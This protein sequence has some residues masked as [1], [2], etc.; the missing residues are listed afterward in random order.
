M[1]E[2]SPQFIRAATLRL[3]PNDDVV[4][5]TREL[6]AGTAIAAE[7]VTTAERIPV[8]HKVA[9]RAV[10]QGQPVRRYNQ[11][12]GTAKVDIAMGQIVSV[13]PAYSY[14]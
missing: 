8:G 12:I 11:I 14:P 2:I 1:G 7:S 10:A 5:A 13:P 9:T 6:P 4:I 3:N